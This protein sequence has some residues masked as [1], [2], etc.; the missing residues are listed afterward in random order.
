[1]KPR[2]RPSLLLAAL[3]LGAAPAAA[4]NL[5]ANG[6]LETGDLAGWNASGATVTDQ[7]VREGAWAARFAGAA[8]MD[9]TFNTVSGR[10]Y[11]AVGWIK[12]VSETGSDW[13]GFSLSATDWQT[14]N[15][16]GG[17]P[18]LTAADSGTNWFKIA[19]TFT[20]AGNAA[21][22]R[23][24][25]FGGP[26]R[27][28]TVHAD[29]IGVYDRT[30]ENLLPQVSFVLDPLSTT[31]A[32]AF[33]TFQVV[34]DDPDGA[35]AWVEWDFG[36][37][38]FS[39]EP[40]G[41][42]RIAV[43][44]NHVARVRVMDDDGGL[45]ET[46]L[47]WSLQPPGGHGIEITQ[48]EIAGSNLVLQGIASGDGLAV[49]FS[50][51]RDVVGEA[52]GAANWSATVPLRPGRNRIRMQ[53]HTAA[54]EV[55]VEETIVSFDPPGPL[56]LST[57]T[58][59]SPS[60]ERWEPLDITFDLLNSAA[61]HPQFPYETHLPRG[62][63]FADGVTVE[64]V[65]A[66][67]TVPG[68]IRVPAFL[69][70]PFAIEERSGLEWARPSGEPVWT[71]R[72]AP[73]HDGAWSVRIEAAEAKG[74]AVSPTA[75]FDVTPPTAP[76]NHGPMQ[77][78]PHD[79]RYYQFADGTPFLGG[80]FGLGSFDAHRFS[81][82]AVDTFDA[83]GPGNA[84]Y[85]RLWLSGVVWGNSWQPWSSRT[86][87]H[88]G[89]VPPYMLSLDSAHG[90][91]LGAFVLDVNPADWND[92]AFNP[93][94]FQG[95]NGQVAS[96]VPGATYRVRV[97]WRTENLSGPAGT[98]PHGVTVKFT[99]WPEPGQTTNAPALVPHVHG[100][101]PWHVAWTDFIADGDFAPNLVIALENV[102][103][104]RAFVDECAIHEVLPGGSLSPPLNGLPKAAGH[105]HFN[106]RRGA[107]LDHIFRA[108]Q[109]RGLSIRAVVSEKQEWAL[110]HLAPAGVRDRRGGH[111][112]T[113]ATNAPTL[114]LHEWHW[115][116]L[117]ARFG[118]F[119]SFAG[120]ELVNEEAPG[121]TDHFRLLGHA[122]RWW[123]RQAHPKP[124]TT[125]TWFGLA[126]DAWKADFA[127][128]ADATSFHA[129]TVGNWLFP[130]AD[131]AILHDSAHYYLAFAQSWLA[132]GFGKP[133]H[134]GEAS[135]FTPQYAE[136]P[137]LAADTNGVW[138]HKWIWAR[139]GPAFV[140]PTYWNADNVF[141]NDLHPLFGNWN[142]FMHGI[143]VANSRYRD[144]EA[145]SPDPRLRFAGQTDIPLGHAHLWIDNR[146]HTWKNVVDGIPVAPVTAAVQL[147]MS[148]PEAAYAVTWFD[149][150][151]GLPTAQANTAAD[152]GGIVHLSVSDLAADTALHLELIGDS[153]WDGDGD[154]IPD[155]WEARHV[156]DLALMNATTDLDR[157]GFRDAA[158]W[159]AGTRPDDPA[160]YLHLRLEGPQ[161]V[162]PSADGR[163]YTIEHTPDL[164]QVEWIEVEGPLSGMP[165]TNSATGLLESGAYRL[166][167]R[168]AP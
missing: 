67:E 90:D 105:L 26:G 25:Y 154:G 138:L 48:A 6:D 91:A 118:A 99:G 77:V 95:F 153:D 30:A 5:L 82:N 113:P 162:W 123:R 100:D 79:S 41:E 32:P 84:S 137:D 66:H 18:Y 42:R 37:G 20:A 73:P 158:E 34:G 117:A 10:A 157:D 103:G 136:H 28:M 106:D 88:E 1:M 27:Q 81:L 101:T 92:P 70:Q 108:A 98:G 112:N 4:A 78:A 63:D 38:T 44:G 58:P 159:I 64:A 55:A 144:A 114:K 36:D 143:P 115:R 116:H 35:I 102:T 31:H 122:A 124:V 111:F 85:F 129:Y 139:T 166:R 54:G 93:L 164:V 87:P 126:E 131:P 160:S 65:F 107:G 128:D 21:R 120:V 39:L 163:I 76:L 155:Q 8:A 141:A 156:H 49:R 19:F 22:L 71:V 152:A 134:W 165:P 50:T 104:G 148:R 167:V 2:R 3:L 168:R 125:S 147:P 60:V 86:R 133:G 130:D 23:L 119:R 72:F 109:D 132:A 89:T 43:P 15:D 16:L 97:R 149:P 52:S 142:R 69:H 83:I 9:Q 59:E 17:T 11:K 96:L 12:I 110:N 40:A 94:I 29:A 151:T 51:D 161:L 62:V 80:G 33:Q 68:E 150:A 45:V 121:P 61:T 53:A 57:P 7:D 56:A 127:A 146:N 47:S 74:Q 140:Y 14:W 145:S 24:G 46:N 135:L 75:T 13:G